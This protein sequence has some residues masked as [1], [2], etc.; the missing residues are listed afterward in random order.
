MET[1]EEDRKEILNLVGHKY[2]EKESNSH[3]K[4][5]DTKS[6]TKDLTKS[7]FKTLSMEVK[8]NLMI[9][10]IYDFELLNYDP[11]MYI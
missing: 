4:I 9:L 10:Y 5:H 1:Y 6:S 7:Y 8:E 3:D 11:Q 2:E